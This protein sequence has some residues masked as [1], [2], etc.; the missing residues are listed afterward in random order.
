MEIIIEK[1]YQ[2]MAASA[3]RD[4]LMLIENNSSPLICP[5]SGDTPAGLYKE[6]VQKIQQ[7]K[8]EISTWKFVGLDEWMGM[9]GSDEGSCRFYLNQQLF[10]PL[11]I[12]PD[13]LCFFDGRQSD[14]QAE[15]M[16]VEEFIQRS[17]GIDVA[18]V[19]LG[20]NGHIGM[21]EPGTD[22]SKRA[23]V[24]MLDGVTKKVGQ[25]YFSKEQELNY[26]LT[27]GMASIMDARYILL[28][29]SGK[30]KAEI[31]HK[32]LESEITNMVPGSL[33]RDHPH[34]RIYLD[35]DAASRLGALPYL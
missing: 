16:K 18:I 23:Y 7:E 19:G 30:H 33:L 34:L 26:G 20:M 25:K 11:N 12:Q 2:A 28:L 21:N 3:A 32:V 22:P 8:K 27:L 4:L 10:S 31:V 24:S 29:V 14:P 9:N 13:R 15:C 5:A 1:D 6:L 35:Q 17:G